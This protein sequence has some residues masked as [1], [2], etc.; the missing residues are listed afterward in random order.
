[1]LN[2]LPGLIKKSGVV[3]WAP[4]TWACVHSFGHKPRDNYSKKQCYH[5]HHHL[6]PCFFRIQDPTQKIPYLKIQSPFTT[7]LGR[8]WPKQVPEED[9]HV[10]AP[11]ISLSLE[12][13]GDKLI[14]P[15]NAIQESQGNEG[16]AKTGSFVADSQGK[17]E[18]ATLKTIKWF[19]ICWKSWSHNNKTW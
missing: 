7:L 8:G 11:V 14:W 6:Q 3:S 19:C 9:R 13:E 16:T 1:M 5:I 17:Q 2:L 10:P 12:M 4:C 18:T 15:I